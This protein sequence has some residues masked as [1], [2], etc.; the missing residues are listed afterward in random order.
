MSQGWSKVPEPG[1]TKAYLGDG[2]FA[3]HDGFS[4]WL[5]TENGIEVTN[6]ICL[7]P[8]VFRALT[9]WKARIAGKETP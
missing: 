5:T 7:E 8:D 9:A 2:V 6:R 4:I 1:P 3:E